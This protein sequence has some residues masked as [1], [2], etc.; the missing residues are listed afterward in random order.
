[1]PQQTLRDL[2][3]NF[4]NG[5]EGAEFFGPEGVRP[6][7]DPGELDIFP[8]PSELP[9]EILGEFA[10]V[11]G[12]NFSTSDGANVTL[13][14]GTGDAPEDVDLQG[15]AADFTPILAGKTEAQ[16]KAELKR[17]QDEGK[18]SKDA[19]LADV[20]GQRLITNPSAIPFIEG[21]ISPAPEAR[22]A[23]T[24]PE[25]QV[26]AE[27]IAETEKVIETF[28]TPPGNRPTKEQLSTVLDPQSFSLSIGGYEQLIIDNLFQ[29]EDPRLVNVIEEAEALDEDWFRD[30]YAEQRFQDDPLWID[31]DDKQKRQV[32][33]ALRTDFA[34][35]RGTDIEARRGMMMQKSGEYGAAKKNAEI[36]DRKIRERMV[37][38]RKTVATEQ[39]QVRGDI[40]NVQTKLNTALGTLAKAQA[41]IGFARTA[42]AKQAATANIK[43][44]N[45]TIKELTTQKTE[46][47][48]RV[49]RE[50]AQRSKVRRGEAVG[51]EAETGALPPVP[52]STA[53][54][55]LRKHPLTPEGRQAALDEISAMGFDPNRINTEG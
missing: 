33:S 24:R 26:P 2:L 7:P 27:K 12:I 9:R 36:L 45:V 41:D 39:R 44:L 30:K 28:R 8:G 14:P 29:G 40:I 31:L 22:I 34:K 13:F 38:E 16:A 47:N 35:I 21:E 43:E 42:E 50:G 52:R 37:K 18:L 49:I 32:A 20:P 11:P 25:V 19:F 23:A 15:L 53:I 48:K 46:L 17:L 51:D 4:S 54:E 6:T 55:I 5:E 10:D 1:M 3:S